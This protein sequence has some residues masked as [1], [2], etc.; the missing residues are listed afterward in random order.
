[1]PSFNPVTITLNGESKTVPANQVLRLISKIEQSFNL[2]E[3]QACKHYSAATVA[4]CYAPVLQF[5]GFTVEEETLAKDFTKNPGMV[6]EVVVWAIDMMR[7]LTAPDDIEM[8]E[9]SEG[10]EGEKKPASE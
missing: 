2:N 8:I 7:L 1:M 4:L 6:A 5:A 10:G 9:G 3:I